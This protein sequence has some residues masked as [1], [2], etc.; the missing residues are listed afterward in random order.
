MSSARFATPQHLKV[1]HSPRLQLLVRLFLLLTLWA[2]IQIPVPLVIKLLIAV[3]LLGG[4][5]HTWRERPELGGE[6]VEIRLDGDGGWRLLQRGEES[7]V[8][9]DALSTLSP[10]L[11]LAI[12]CFAPTGGGRRRCYLL[13]RAEQPAFTFRHLSLYLRLYGVEGRA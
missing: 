2:T 10:T 6:A 3:A 1:G 9:L 5:I 8:Q 7:T 4:V 13:W 11:G 12:L